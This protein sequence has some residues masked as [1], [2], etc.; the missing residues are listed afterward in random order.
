[1]VGQTP[2]P[3]DQE[4]QYSLR[5]KGRL[6]EP[7]EFQKIVVRMNS[8]GSSIRLG[9]IARVELGARDYGFYSDTQG[10]PTAGFS[11][12]LSPDANALETVDNCI[13]VIETAAQKIPQRPKI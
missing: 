6:S 3:A 11:I 5:A 12:Q 2:S 9:D 1:M 8:D 7:E 4:H 13:K 10:Q